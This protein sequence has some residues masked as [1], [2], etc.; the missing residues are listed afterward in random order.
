MHFLYLSKNLGSVVIGYDIACVPR[1][2]DRESQWKLPISNIQ[3]RS[4]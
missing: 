1:N 3:V 2:S 4:A